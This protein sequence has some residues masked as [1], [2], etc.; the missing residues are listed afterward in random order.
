MIIGNSGKL[1]QLANVQLIVKDA[2]LEGVQ[3]I[4]YLGVIINENLSW[5]CH[6]ESFPAKFVQRLGIP[7]RIKHLL[8]RHARSL[9]VKTIIT[10]IMEYSSR[11]WGDRGS[12]VLMDN[13]Q[14]LHSK[15]AKLV[16]DR[17]MLSSSSE[18]LNSLNWV[19]L[20][21]RRSIYRCLYVHKSIS[22]MNDNEF[23]RNSDV[24]GYNTRQKK[25]YHG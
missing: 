23:I 6:I 7:R 12:K 15:A 16:L 9:F 3:S 5:K 18:P 4:K 10:S 24:H 8:P 13:I 11:I 19:T 21:Q 2:T 25:L 14:V 17:P 1:K 22:G 20:R